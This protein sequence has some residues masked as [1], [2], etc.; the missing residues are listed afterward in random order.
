MSDESILELERVVR[1]APGDEGA[2]LRLVAALVRAGRTRDALERLDLAL[3]SSEQLGSARELSKRLWLEELGSLQF[4]GAI[5]LEHANAFVLSLS[6][7]SGRRWVA[8]SSWRSGLYVSSPSGEPILVD[9]NHE[10]RPVFVHGGILAS[11]GDGLTFLEW[12]GTRFDRRTLPCGT[13]TFLLGASP[14]GDRILL[15]HWKR[16]RVLA[17]PSLDVVLEVAV[18]AGP[19]LVDWIAERLLVPSRV[20]VAAWSFSGG[21][22]VQCPFKTGHGDP[23]IAAPG[24]IGKIWPGLWLHGH[25]HGW[26]KPVVRS[27]RTIPMPSF[28]SDRRTLRLVIGGSTRRF[29]LDPRTGALDPSPDT[30]W[31]MPVRDDAYV[32][33]HPHADV[34]LAGSSRPQTVAV[35]AADGKTLREFNYA[36]ARSTWSRDGRTLAAVRTPARRG[37]PSRIEVW[38][39]TM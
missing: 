32:C 24:V 23:F 16:A 17:W 27:R 39:V 25:E 18:A 36:L 37:G 2:R 11:H 38:G 34:Y 4:L 6:V 10:G 1:G 30:A 20:G 12:S 31:P 22:A 7:D 21:P 13:R 3:V 8:W 9:P 26:T 14:L 29:L 33:W 28:A 19:V 15:R 35:R 5:P